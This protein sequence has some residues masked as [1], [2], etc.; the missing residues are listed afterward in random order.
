MKALAAAVALPRANSSVPPLWLVCCLAFV[1]L[2]A[3][4]LMLI[5]G[6]GT[7][8]A[9][10]AREARVNEL[11]R[12]RVFGASADT[13]AAP[14]E[15]RSRLSDV[16]T[17]LLGVV[18]RYVRARGQR[19]RII[20]RLERSGVHMRPEEWAAIEV[21]AIVAGSAAMAS[22]LGL[23]LGVLVGGPAGWLL[24]YLFLT[25]KTARRRRAFE[26]QLPDAL[27]LMAGALRTGFGLT[28]S[29]AAVTRDAADPVAE[30]F[31][32]VMQEVRLGAEL[33]DA[34]DGLAARMCSYDLSLIVMAIRTAREIGGNMAE[35]LQTAVATMRE[36]VQLSRQ[37]RV[38]TAEGRLSAKLLTGL[39]ILMAL[40]LLFFKKGYLKPLYTTPMGIV[41]L[42]VG[43]VLLLLGSLWLRKLT[44]IEV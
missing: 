27:Q 15:R 34:L 25:T 23:I 13:A 19:E 30:E 24:C 9:R 7:A 20:G 26:Q 16:T 29:I 42:V 35:V 1:G 5:L 8:A 22:L 44:K 40:Y 17:R 10:R 36:R 41:M 37:V 11:R 32:R 12:Y 3:V 31:S 39:P 18:D 4:A 38:L 21:S 43:S 33:E 2:L 14:T 28:Q 6:P